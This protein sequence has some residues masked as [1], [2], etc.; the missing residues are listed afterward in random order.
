MEATVSDEIEFL[1]TENEKLHGET[2]AL[3][4]L[5]ASL[6]VALRRGPVVGDGP[7]AQVFETAENIIVD[8]ALKHGET[9]SPHHTTGAGYIL[10]SLRKQVF[11]SSP[12]TGGGV[13]R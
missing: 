9:A 13:D 11:F 2:L 12:D 8:I 3:Q 10:E 7:V 6:L 5:L 4:W 1:K